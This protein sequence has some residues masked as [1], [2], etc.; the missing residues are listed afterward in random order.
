MDALITR[1]TRSATISRQ[2]AMMGLC[3]PLILSGSPLISRSD[4]DL[5]A[6][7]V[8]LTPDGTTG[9]LPIW[10]T[11]K[12]LI[13]K[14]YLE[15]HQAHF[16]ELDV[17]SSA[18]KEL[19]PRGGGR[20]YYGEL[21]PSRQQMPVQYVL[22][23]DGAHRIYAAYGG[24][25]FVLFDG[26]VPYK[27]LF[28]AGIKDDRIG[29][30]LIWH[31]YDPAEV[32][33]FE[34]G[35]P[36]LVRSEWSDQKYPVHFVGF[37]HRPTELLLW[38]TRSDFSSTRAYGTNRCCNLISIAVVDFVPIKSVRE[39]GLPEGVSVGDVALSPDGNTLAWLLMRDHEPGR[40]E[41]WMLQLRQSGD[42]KYPLLVELATSRIDGTEWRHIVAL[43]YIPQGP[44]G[45]T[46]V[47]CA[48]RPDHLMWRPDGRY[49]SF[50]FKCAI[51]MTK[52]E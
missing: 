41:S 3:L 42:S 24:R 15:D 11:P 37:R 10:S 33:S 23:R 50:V 14:R 35:A 43:P 46:T 52:V 13:V 30:W 48:Y 38:D 19:K 5:I 21:V 6:K 22:K 17:E 9:N 12:R 40:F 51:W 28:A 16:S 2:T 44:D 39:I 47:R 31:Q 32:V 49:V 8:R 20:G 27:F 29:D 1:K 26:R 45:T 34:V 36:P 4:S 7:S 25:A 18:W